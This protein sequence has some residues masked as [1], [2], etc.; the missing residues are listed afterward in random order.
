[1]ILISIYFSVVEFFVEQPSAFTFHHE[2][3]DH[4]LLGVLFRYLD[5]PASRVPEYYSTAFAVFN[6]LLIRCT[7]V[8]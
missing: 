5:S 1:M 2:S 7:D 8:D 4:H 3:L 6:R